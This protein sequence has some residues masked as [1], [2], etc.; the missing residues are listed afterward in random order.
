MRNENDKIIR[1]LSI[2][3]DLYTLRRMLDKNYINNIVFYA[4]NAHVYNLINILV[5]E[6]N[7]KIINIYE[8]D[9]CEKQIKLDK[10]FLYTFYEENYNDI[11][12]NN[13]VPIQCVD[14]N[15]FPEN[16]FE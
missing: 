11:I 5:Y 1:L 12:N 7:F 6:F 16:I 10:N 14:L 15:K 3:T 2:I 9:K 8:D 13:C 4:G